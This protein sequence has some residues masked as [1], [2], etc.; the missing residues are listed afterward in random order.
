GCEAALGTCE[1]TL[2]ATRHGARSSPVTGF[3]K[4]WEYMSPMIT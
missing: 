1:L 3:G 4:F 2:S